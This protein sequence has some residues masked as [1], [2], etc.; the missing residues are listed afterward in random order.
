MT[1]ERNRDDR[2]DNRRESRKTQGKK[3]EKKPLALTFSTINYLT[4]SKQLVASVQATRGNK[5]AEAVDVQL[6]VPP[7]TLGTGKTDRYGRVTFTLDISYPA[8]TYSLIAETTGGEQAQTTGAFTVPQPYEVT[9]DTPV[10]DFTATIEQVKDDFIVILSINARRGTA[11]IQNE[12]ASITYSDG[13]PQ[14]LETVMTDGQGHAQKRLTIPAVGRSKVVTDIQVTLYRLS[15]APSCAKTIVATY[16]QKKLKQMTWVTRPKPDGTFDWVITV[17]DIDDKPAAGIELVGGCDHGEITP[18]KQTTNAHGQATFT[19]K[20]STDHDISKFTADSPGLLNNAK[21]DLPGKETKRGWNCTRYPIILAGAFAFLTLV[22]L[23]WF[24]IDVW[25]VGSSYMD[26]PMV[27]DVQL[28]PADS[29]RNNYEKSVYT[30]FDRDFMKSKSTNVVA[31]QRPENP[32]GSSLARLILLAVLSFLTM[33][34]FIAISLYGRATQL[35][36]W[37]TTFFRE[38]R[39]GVA[40]NMPSVWHR[41]IN[42]Y[43]EHN[44]Q[45]LVGQPIAPTGKVGAQ[46]S[47]QKGIGLMHWMPFLMY[48]GGELIVEPLAKKLMDVFKKKKSEKE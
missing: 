7:S 36:D 23:C 37:G 10:V 16:E 2:R 26:K 34:V 31:E 32:S 15:N 48:I 3:E 14:R 40:D 20:P 30:Y 22:F 47:E 28:P 11:P 29:L 18:D 39:S 4:T 5:P 43:L 41:W 46:P 6:L 13:G 21:I 33:L 25:S 17:E 9:D 1:E 45:P 12:S 24:G 38:H 27:K 19:V 42:Q 35:L 8:K 44:K